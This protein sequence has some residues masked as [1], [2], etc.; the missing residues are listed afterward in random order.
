VVDLKDNVHYFKGKIPCVDTG[1]F[2]FTVRV[3]PSRKRLEN[4]FI[5]GLVTW[6]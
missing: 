5:M 2:G 4:P 1:R 6:A 3:M